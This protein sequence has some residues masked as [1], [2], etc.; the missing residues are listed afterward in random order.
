MNLDAIK[1]GAAP[2][3]VGP[4]SQAVKMGDWLFCSGQIGLNPEDGKLVSGGV[5]AETRQALANLDAVLQAAG[6][7]RQSVV[8]TT[9]FIT[10]MAAF[11]TVNAVYAAYFMSPFPARSTVQ[12][13]ALP[14]G[15]C[16]EIEAVAHG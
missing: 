9:V 6:A 12:V 5:E 4:Y 13:G 15:A 14:K 3:A 8:K 1:T 11:P 10:D 7:S 2:A 16:V